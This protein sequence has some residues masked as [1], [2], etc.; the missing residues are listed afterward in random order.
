M[1]LG[2]L[3]H[4]E[5]W[6][7]VVWGGLHGLYLSVHKLI[8]GNRK[9]QDR[10]QPGAIG[11]AVLTALSA[12]GTFLAV[13]I[14]WVFFRARNVGAA[15]AY[16]RAMASFRG[17]GQMPVV[18]LSILIP[19]IPILA[20]DLWQSR[21]QDELFFLRWRRWARGAFYAA[22]VVGIVVGGGTRAPFIYMQY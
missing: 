22:I 7:Y 14:A 15:L 12:V 20:I 6:H 16:L 11:P 10:A 2:G 19:W 1:L 13:S 8:M 21:R 3:W 4:G 17:M 18:L 9:A 5:R